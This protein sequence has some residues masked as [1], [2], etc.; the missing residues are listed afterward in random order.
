MIQLSK[1]LE[2]GTTDT[3]ASRYCARCTG[4]DRYIVKFNFWRRGKLKFRLYITHPPQVSQFQVQPHRKRNPQ[5][6]LWNTH[7]KIQEKTDATDAS[8]TRTHILFAKL[9]DNLHSRQEEP[10][11]E[12]C[13]FWC[14][15]SLSFILLM[16]LLSTQPFH[17]HCTFRY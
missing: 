15:P 16:I 13:S 12:Y 17:S 6:G 11:L 3:M 8:H 9:L 5:Y 7:M 2:L 10:F 4:T 14:N 1:P